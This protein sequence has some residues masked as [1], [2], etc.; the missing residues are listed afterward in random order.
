MS[1]FKRCPTTK[2]KDGE[3]LCNSF[4]YATE[5]KAALRDWLKLHF[6]LGGC[7]RLSGEVKWPR[8]KSNSG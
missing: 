5:G 1:P 8:N 7:G 2:L 4:V 6:G 3:G